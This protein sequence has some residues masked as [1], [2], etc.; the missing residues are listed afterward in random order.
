[1]NIR[2]FNNNDLQTVT[3]LEKMIFPN[4]KPEQVFLEDGHKYYVLEENG[5]VI[6]YAGYEKIVDE[7]HLINMAVAEAH[8]KQG[9]GRA[10]IEQILTKSREDQI[11][12]LILEVRISN[13]P[14][15][16]LYEK[17][18]FEVIAKRKKYYENNNEDALVM[19]KKF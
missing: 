11:K 16:S 1:M 15:I 4:P 3:N 8:R 2:R 18:G 13:H 19:A 14:A 9:L 12:R 6:G 17:M 10:L 5:E 7:G